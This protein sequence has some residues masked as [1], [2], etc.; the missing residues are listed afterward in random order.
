MENKNVIGNSYLQNYNGR[1]D[2]S[3]F[4]YYNCNPKYKRTDDCVIRAVATGIGRSWEEALNELVSYMIEDGHMLNTPELYGKY[5]CEHGWAKQKQPTK[6]GKKITF[7][8]FVKS[9]KGNAIANAG[10]GHVTYV[11]KGKVW[12]IWDCTDEIVG[13]YWIYVGE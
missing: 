13:N 5:L 6:N 9:F 2:T 8:E 11:S 3:T 1:F 7:A 12:D 10:D 4:S